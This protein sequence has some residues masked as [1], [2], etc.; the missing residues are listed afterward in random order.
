MDDTQNTLRES[1]VE[2]LN[3]VESKIEPEQPVIETEVEDKPDRVRDTNGKFAKKE[4]EID[5]TVL[6]DKP[7]V[8]EAESVIEPAP[9]VRPSTWKKD[10]WDK[11]DALDTDLQNYINQRET[12][13][14]TGVSVYKAEADRAKDINEA[15]TPFMP[16]LQRNNIA[17][18]QWIKNLG[19]AHQTLVYGNPA[20]KAQMFQQLARDY[21]I[22]LGQFGGDYQ[23]PEVDQN[24]QWLT[25]QVQGLSQTLN[26]FKDQQAQAE[27]AQI[28]QTIKQFADTHPHYEAV[29]IQMAQLLES[30]IVQDLP[31]AYDKAIRL[32]DETW[33]SVMEAKT[34]QQSQADVVNKAKS[35]AVSTKSATPSGTSSNSS[36]KGLREQLSDAI[37]AASSRV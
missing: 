35:A 11:F 24:T 6:D 4:V 33:Q 13:F 37:D 10:Y 21:N 19:S 2:A 5:K 20:Q 29:R 1:I 31:T 23:A 14:K 22:D 3:T 26:S 16:D 28:Q 18:S 9:R 17:P 8:Q 25:Q 34:K 32:N 12:E 36:G 30:G 27:Q 15:L 7:I